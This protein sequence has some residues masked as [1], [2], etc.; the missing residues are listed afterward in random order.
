M[1]YDYVFYTDDPIWYCILEVPR[2]G[3]QPNPPQPTHRTPPH[4]TLTADNQHA[5]AIAC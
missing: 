1:V 2:G 4:S 5:Y 3:S